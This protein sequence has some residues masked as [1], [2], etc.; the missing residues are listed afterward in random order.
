MNRINGTAQTT[1]TTQAL[2]R[3]R[4][5]FLILSF[6]YLICSYSM[7]GECVPCAMV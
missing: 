4:P 5:I 3:V 7:P 1:A 2:Y 6:I